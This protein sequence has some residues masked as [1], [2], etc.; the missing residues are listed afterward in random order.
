MIR[1]AV[2]V[3]NQRV[4]LFWRPRLAFLKDLTQLG[5]LCGGKLRR[6]AAAEAWAQS[7][8]ATVIPRASPP[9]RRGSG[10]PDASPRL[11]TRITLIEV[12]NV[13]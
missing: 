1:D 2:A 13:A 7:L 6:P 10:D 8:D 11:L 12:P 4:N 3:F 5:E 9:A